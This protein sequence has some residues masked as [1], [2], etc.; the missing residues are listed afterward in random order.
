MLVVAL[1]MLIAI[2]LLGLN[3]LRGSSLQV[4]M[5]SG[6]YDRQIAFHAAESGLRQAEAAVA[7]GANP[8]FD[9]TNGLFPTPVPLSNGTFVD[10]W[11][12]AA[13]AWR[14]ATAVASGPKTPTPQY[15][16]EDLG[17]WESWYLCN[18][19]FP[20]DALCLAPVYRITARSGSA[21]NANQIMLQE[22]FRP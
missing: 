21:G 10:R 19:A 3:S 14:D 18:N 7:I 12:N 2:M 15:I 4:R 22:T 11:T 9:G 5:G 17:E 16:A 20:K 13:T 6:I 1:V 8:V